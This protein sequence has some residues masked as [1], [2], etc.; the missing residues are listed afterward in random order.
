MDWRD[1]IPEPD[2]VPTVGMM[3]DAGFPNRFAYADVSDVRHA[4]E[5]WGANDWWMNL[6]THLRVPRGVACWERSG[7][8]AT[9]LTVLA[10]RLMC[11]RNLPVP[12]GVRVGN[13]GYIDCAEL[14]DNTKA[15]ETIK[16]GT[17]MVGG[18]GAVLFGEDRTVDAV[19]ALA[20]MRVREGCLTLWHL[21]PTGTKTSMNICNR[22][23]KLL[24]DGVVTLGE[25]R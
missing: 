20:Q 6:D 7:V 17:L 19:G 12:R 22:L 24:D 21:H 3:V 1:Y 16:Y 5:W 2:E 4:P 13:V 14:A 11:W 25:P 15:R 23:L 8:G 18:V 10:K 9:V